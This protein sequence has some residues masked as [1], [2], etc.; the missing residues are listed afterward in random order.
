MVSKNNIR[1]DS[2][3]SEI[4]KGV[5]AETPQIPLDLPL[6]VSITNCV[7]IS[8]WKKVRRWAAVYFVLRKINFIIHHIVYGEEIFYIEEWNLK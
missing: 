1:M 8:A 3:P 6:S 5:S 4:L 2:Q 7:E